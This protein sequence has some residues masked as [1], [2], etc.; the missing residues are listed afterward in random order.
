VKDDDSN[1]GYKSIVEQQQ[2]EEVFLG[3]VE[4]QLIEKS[5]GKGIHIVWQTY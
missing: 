2:V 3:E 4:C 1:A 5:G